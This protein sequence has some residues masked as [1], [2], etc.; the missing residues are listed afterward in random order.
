M[1]M[2]VAMLTML[3]D[4]VGLVFF[5]D[6]E[7][8]RVIGR[9]AFPLY[10]FGIVQGYRYTSN[11]KR[12]FT[13]LAGLA[14]IS[15]IPYVLLFDV[16]RL[17]VIFLFLVA[18]LSLYVVDHCKKRHAVP[19]VFFLAILSSP[20]IEYGVYGILLVFVYRYF[21][22]RQ[23]V[24][25]HLLLSGIYLWLFKDGFYLQF[26]A[27]AASFLIVYREKILSYP[28]KINRQFYRLFYPA[29]LAVL[30]LISVVIG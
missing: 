7:W 1:I 9:I 21:E 20:F 13:R 27:V 11:L 23:I 24:L 22:G 19:F 6:Q 29:H 26:C 25:G 28:V 4:H 8:L 16:T 3:I 2:L 15:Q 14:V 10:A 18:L 12:Y 30:L 5:P 17:N